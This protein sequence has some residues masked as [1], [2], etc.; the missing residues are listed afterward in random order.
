VGSSFT[1]YRASGFWTRDA[2]I[3]P[4]LYLLAAEARRLDDS[5]AWLREAADDWLTQATVG[6]GGCV[7]AGLNEH[8]STPER[9]AVVLEVA[10]RALAGLRAQGELIRM[11]WLNSLGLGGPGATFTRDWPAEVFLRVGEALVRLLRGDITWDASTSP[12]L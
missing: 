8:A 9:A 3:E 11:D 12:V 1:E 6:M 4:W 5:P 7:S 2:S 10:E